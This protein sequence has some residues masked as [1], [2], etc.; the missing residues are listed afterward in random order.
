[1][2][3]MLNSDVVEN[4]GQVNILYAEAAADWFVIDTHV[5]SFTLLFTVLKIQ[6]VLPVL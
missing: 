4:I 1:M 5:G 3:L 6:M 2:T